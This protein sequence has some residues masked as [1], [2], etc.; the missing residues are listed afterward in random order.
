MGLI[1]ETEPHTTGAT[2]TTDTTDTRNTGKKDSRLLFSDACDGTVGMGQQDACVREVQ[3]LLARA[4]ADIDVDSQFGPQTL[5]RVTAFQV[6]A[7]I[8]PNGVVGEQTKKALYAQKTRMDTWSP[9]KVRQRVREVFE[10]EPTAPPPSPTAS[11]SSIRSTSCR[12]PTAPGT[13][14]S[15]RSPTP[16]CG[17]WA[18]HRARPS[19]RNGTSRPPTG[20]G[21]APRTSAP[22]PTATGRTRVPRP[23]PRPLP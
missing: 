9:E 12:T 1:P 20:C 3:R 23:R 14:A 16:R 6:L 13:G 15:S 10:E 5:R 21:S 8:A 17:S 4:G 11:P 18:G 7:G 22:G 2:N 19:N